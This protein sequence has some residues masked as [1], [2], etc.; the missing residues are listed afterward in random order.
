MAA[1]RHRPSSIDLLPPETDDL[2]AWAYGELKGGK[3]F[4]QDVLAEFN[5]RLQVRALELGV[6]LP[7]ISKSAFSRSALRLRRL[8]QRLEE[9]R[10]IAAVLAEKFETGGGEDVTLLVGE[11]IKT[12]VLEVLE[13]AG[14][15]KADG[16]TAE[17]L[18]NFALAV[19]SAE[20]ARKVSADTASRIRKDFLTKAE[21]AI[22]EVAAKK[23][24]GPEA[25]KALYDV[26]TGAVDAARARP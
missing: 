7:A 6:E 4:Q 26:M 5:R 9:T 22:E 11:T 14:S 19:K 10:E 23:G 2:V 15:L 13:N 20:Q 21:A 8:S 12:L 18:A 1:R 17:M 24:L 3:R 16:R 25:V